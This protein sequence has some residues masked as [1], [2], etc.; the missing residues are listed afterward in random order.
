MTVTPTALA[1]VGQVKSLQEL[2]FKMFWSLSK[3]ICK[4]TPKKSKLALLINP[5]TEVIKHFTQS[6]EWV[7]KSPT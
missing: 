5:L 1:G 3:A 2:Y 6:F 7:Q 4:Y